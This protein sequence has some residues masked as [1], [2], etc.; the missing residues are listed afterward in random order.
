MVPGRALRPS[1][2]VLPEHAR[3]HN[4]S[5]VLQSLYRSGRVSRADLARLTGLTRVT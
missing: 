2:K 5:L 1:V 3:N 4:R